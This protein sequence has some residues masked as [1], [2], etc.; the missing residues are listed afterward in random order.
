M[1]FW[2]RK[3]VRDGFPKEF[4]VQRIGVSAALA[5]C[6]LAPEQIAASFRRDSLAARHLLE[7]SCDKRYSPSTF[8][9]EENSGY[10]VGWYSTRSGYECVR[11]FS[12]L[13][14]AATDYLLFSLGKRRWTAPESAT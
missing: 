8:I 10:S 2:K 6:E 5:V 14:D 13:E 4:R 12:N 1:Y 7:E 9:S 3:Q 11:R